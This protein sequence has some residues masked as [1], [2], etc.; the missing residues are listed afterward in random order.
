MNGEDDDGSGSDES[1]DSS[2]SDSDSE[3]SGIT[4]MTRMNRMGVIVQA[5]IQLARKVF[6]QGR[7]YL[8]S[9]FMEAEAPKTELKAAT[10]SITASTQVLGADGDVKNTSSAKAG[11]NGDGGDIDDKMEADTTAGYDRPFH[12]PQFEIVQQSPSDH[13]YLDNVKQVR[14]FLFSDQLV[15]RIHKLSDLVYPSQKKKT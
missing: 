7:I 15:K 8:K 12:L 11:I 1:D 3:D 9:G 10:E 5:V 4:W 14:N 6:A 13:H 2:G